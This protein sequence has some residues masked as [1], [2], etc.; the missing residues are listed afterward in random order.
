ME[1]ENEDPVA[2]CIHALETATN[3]DLAVAQAKV[4]YQSW[5][6]I[7][8]S[9]KNYSMSQLNELWRVSS[10]VMATIASVYVWNGDYE[11]ASRLE[12]HFLY[13]ERLWEKDNRQVIDIYLTLLLI[14]KQ[15]DH[16]KRI[17]EYKEFR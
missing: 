6:A 10:I 16:L 17:S 7:D 8:V 11:G 4:A 2:V 14:Q 15:T 9:D 13:N 12:D 3:K 1:Q 5:R